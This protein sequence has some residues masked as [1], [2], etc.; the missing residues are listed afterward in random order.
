[1]KIIGT[2]LVKNEDRFIERIVRNVVD[3]CDH[4]IIKDNVSTDDTYRLLEPL[5][6]EY[7]HIELH[8]IADPEESHA[9]VIPYVGTDCWLFAVDGDEI[10]DPAGLKL[11]RK[12]LEAGLYN[13]WWVIF[14][15]VLN[16]TQVDVFRK[17]AMGYLAP[18]SRSM[19]KIF[20]F[21]LI[22]EWSGCRHRVSGGTPV[23]KEGY[24][25]NLRNNLYK[26]CSWEDADFRC[27]HTCFTERS[28]LDKPNDRGTF[29]RVNI[30][31]TQHVRPRDRIFDPFRKW[32]GYPRQSPWKNEK[33][34][35]GRLVEKDVTVFFPE[36]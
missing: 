23:F 4:L 8:Q 3:F 9:Y 14:G 1:M 13:D 16:C 34:S 33:Y 30:S 35:R 7:D 18:P 22:S 36:V 2:I 17:R 25:I 15:N 27:L 32:L 20:N 10:Y 26:T 24:H 6:Q 29:A 28:S 12:E 19:T 21:S 31:E 11:F 5:A